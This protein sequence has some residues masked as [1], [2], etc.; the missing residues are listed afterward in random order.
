MERPMTT[1]PSFPYPTRFP[2]FRSLIATLVLAGLCVSSFAQKPKVLA[3]HRSVPPKVEKRIPLKEAAPGSTVAGP[4][5]IDAN[6]KSTIY[7]KNLVE[8]SEVSVTPI[9]YLSNGVKFALAPVQLAPA[10]IAIIDVNASLQN[11]GIAPYATLNGYVELQYF[12]AWEP[13]CATVRNLD[14]LH[15]IIFDYGA[16]ST[17]SIQFANQPPPTPGPRPITFEGMWWK[18]EP[19]VTGF[20][21]LSNTTVEA[22]TAKLELSDNHGSDFWR[23]TVTISPHGTKL[24]ELNQL[25]SAPTSE[26]GIRVSYS[27]SENDLLING[28]L[29][30]QTNGYSASLHFTEPMLL[31]STSNVTI[32]ELGL[33]SGPADPMLAFPA[34]VV[35]TPYTVLRNSSSA[36]I[37]GTPTFWWMAGGTAQSAQLPALTLRA[38]ETRT[39]DIPKMLASAGLK[40]FSGSISLV[41][42]VQGNSAGLLMAGGSVDQKYT[43]VFAVVPK[44]V[45]VS[46]AKNLS[47]WSIGNGDDTMMTLWNAADDAQDLIFRLMF[48]GGH[49]DFPIHLGP[50]TTQMFNVSEIVRSQTPD[51]DGNIIPLGITDGSAELMGAQGEVDSM[52]VAMEA[53][54][55]NVKK[56]TC[57]TYSC[58]TCNGVTDGSLYPL[59]SFTLALGTTIQL[60][61]IETWNSGVQY[62][63]NGGS[64][65]SSSNTSVATVSSSGLVTGFVAGSTNILAQDRY[66][67][68]SYTAQFCGVNLPYCPV[69]PAFQPG[70]ISKVTVR[71]LYSAKFVSNNKNQINSCP[72]GQAGWLRSI[73]EIIVDQSGNPWTNDGILMTESVTLTRNDFG[74]PCDNCNGKEDTYG[75]GYFDDRY[76]F[77]A[78]ACVAP[79]NGEVDATQVYFYNGVPVKLTNSLVYKCASISWNGK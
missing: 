46:A 63:M 28:G 1:P 33:M 61:L 24:I 64:N 40:N 32:A 66:Y 53:G 34:D 42:D 18:Q 29:Q 39:L 49:Y 67:E 59:N 13:I 5:M 52:L 2:S 56:A 72:S 51:V 17:T 25:L 30:D 78:P 19:N 76:S 43:Y 44:G 55:Y 21:T 37:T 16:R 41:F 8:T 31:P 45:K 27:G 69:Q 54:I 57:G 62:N 35:F 10:G 3:P 23:D 58:Q 65:W 38:D 36:P 20:V 4:W 74:A 79:T 22:V 7:V 73:H 68:P 47:Y 11:L 14:T 26:G 71:A 50:R 75:G 12:W 6:F 9:L 77:C 48:T 70:G 60:N 15:S